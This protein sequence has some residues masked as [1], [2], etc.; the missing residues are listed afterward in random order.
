MKI[1]RGFGEGSKSRTERDADLQKEISAHLDLE[2]EE[3]QDSGLSAKEARYAASRTFGNSTIV[4]EDVRKA[5][6][7]LWLEQ[8][9]QDLRYGFR[10]LWKTP[11]FSIVAVLSLALGIGGNVA[12]FSLVNGVLLRPLPYAQPQNLVR[13]TG[14]YPKGAMAAMQQMTATMDIA[15][16]ATNGEANLTGRGEAMHLTYSGVSANFFQLLGEQAQIGRVFAPGDDHPGS[17]Q[18]ILLSHAFWQKEF[19][20]DPGIIGRILTIDGQ[21]RQVIGVMPATFHFP[22]DDTKF[23]IPLRMNP[24]DSE[25]FWGKGFMPLIGRLRPGATLPQAQSELHSMIARVIPLFSFPMGKDWNSKETVILLQQDFTGNVRGRLLLLL[26][27]VAVVLLIAC[28]NVASLLLARSASRS[29]E[30]GLRSALGAA[31][32][33]LIRQFLTESVALALAGSLIGLLFAFGGLSILKSI[34]PADTPLLAQIGIDLPVLLYMVLLAVFT[35]LVSG[36]IP[37]LS[38]TKLDIGSLIKTGGQRSMGVSG[39]RLRGVFIAAEVAMAVVL[40]VAAGL[41]VKS[42]W[43][44]TEANPGFGAEQILTTRITPSRGTC[45]VRAVCVSFYDELVRRTRGISGVSEVAAVNALPL[46][47]K[48]PMVPAELEGHSLVAAE[49][50]APL[51]WASA[52]T[53]KYFQV[54]HIHLLEGREFSESDGEKSQPVVIVSSATAKRY[55]PKESPIGKHIRV[56]WDQQWR[57]VVGVVGDVQEYTLAT[58]LPDWVSGMVYMPYPQSVD[59][60]EQIPLAMSIIIKTGSD[61]GGVA[62]GVR[63]VASDLNPNIPVG[64]IRSMGFLVSNSA[65]SSRSMM[66]L[67][68]VFAASALLLAAIGTYGVVSYSASQRTYEMGVRVAL[69]ATRTNLFGIVL[70]Q[71][72][73]L[74]LAGLA[75]GVAVSLVVTRVLTGFLYGVSP[76]DPL[77][78]LAVVLLLIAIALLAGFVPARRA[79]SIDPVTALRVD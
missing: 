27:S 55:W 8:L 20:S 28:V 26:C 47:G 19:S 71:S 6:G 74:V 37:A 54:M 7:W 9:G 52:V 63:S 59:L 39:V 38:A 77:T 36:V 61:A 43:R 58:T 53:P 32:S 31:R 35:G 57:T 11:G 29:K 13:L 65:S 41:L 33:R 1:R 78:L 22:P 24:A 70:G 23:W 17:D 49:T 73:R 69:G 42:L 3:Q 4:E 18:L 48:S 45:D 72:L 50:T 66:W 16:I 12:M 51:L 44:M 64:E 79:A 67:F 14:F 5:W 15:A 25:D 60:T 46:E 21:G 34:L 62:A 75:L 76:T 68:V 30:I 56:V 10:A 2:T 40:A